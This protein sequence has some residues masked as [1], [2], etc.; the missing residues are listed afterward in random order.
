MRCSC[1][2]PEKLPLGASDS[3]MRC[4]RVHCN[5]VGCTE[6]GYSQGKHPL[7]RLTSGCTLCSDVH[8]LLTSPHAFTSVHALLAFIWR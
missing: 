7:S 1:R 5:V 2:A 8:S 6:K 4:H 3:A